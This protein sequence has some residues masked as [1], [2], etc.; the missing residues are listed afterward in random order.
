MLRGMFP[1]Q[2]ENKDTVYQIEGVFEMS[3]ELWYYV[4]TAVYQILTKTGHWL[5]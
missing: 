4:D 5:Q 3:Y 2:S 1:R